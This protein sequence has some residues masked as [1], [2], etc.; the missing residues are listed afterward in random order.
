MQCF[1]N[2]RGIKSMSH[3]VKLWVRVVE[4]R[5]RSEVCSL[6]S[7]MLRK[8]PTDTIALGVLRK[9]RESQ[10]FHCVFEDLEAYAKRRAVLVHEAKPQQ[11]NDPV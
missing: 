11:P 4:A 9:Y 8:S 6:S 10:E 1:S 7:T 2:Y 5:L 3:T